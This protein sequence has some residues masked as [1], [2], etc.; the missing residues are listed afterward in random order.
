MKIVQRLC[1][2]WFMPPR[3]IGFGLV[4]AAAVAA[5]LT[6]A[7]VMH[8][9]TFSLLH[10]FKAGPLGD[11]PWAGP[12]LDP[13]GNLYGTAFADGAHFGGTVYKLSTAGKLTAL[14]NFTGLKGDGQEPYYGSL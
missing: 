6:A 12:V 1:K 11:S 8:A 14:Y 7:P 3:N 9:Q 4:F 5:A 2:E 10:K 13:M